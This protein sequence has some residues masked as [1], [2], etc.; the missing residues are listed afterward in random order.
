MIVCEEK[1]KKGD[2]II[3][4]SCGDMGVYDKCD[5]KG[6]IHFKYYYGKMFNVLKDC[7][8]WNLQ[9]N[10]QKFYELCDD[11]EKEEMDFIIKEGR[12]KSDIF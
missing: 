8:K 11:K 1:F 7:E 2:Y 12:Y 9:L 3:N 10:Y 4:R 6:Y 5:N